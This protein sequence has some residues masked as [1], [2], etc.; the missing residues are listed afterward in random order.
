MRRGVRGKV[1]E[2]RAVSHRLGAAA[3]LIFISMGLW[4]V[5]CA[6]MWIPILITG[7]YWADY[8]VPVLAL[9]AQF[10]VIVFAVAAAIVA[11]IEASRREIRALQA[12]L[13][14]LGATLMIT[15]GPILLWWDS[16]PGL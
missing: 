10:T 5:N 7:R 8:T 2:R 11:I 3:I 16:L 1:S 9:G 14:L 15:V 4:A 6:V 13:V 12:T